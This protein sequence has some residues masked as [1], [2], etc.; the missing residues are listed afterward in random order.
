MSPAI[1]P[2]WYGELDVPDS[3]D[4][5]LSSGEAWSPEDDKGDKLARAFFRFSSEREIRV[6]RYA[7]LENNCAI[8]RPMPRLPPVMRT[9]FGRLAMVG[10]VLFGPDCSRYVGQGR[11]VPETQFSFQKQWQ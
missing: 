5:S 9:C 11:E 7:F 10:L 2:C 6:Q 3:L 8:A 1:C 4:G